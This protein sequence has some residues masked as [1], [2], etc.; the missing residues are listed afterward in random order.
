VY[1]HELHWFN[2]IWNWLGG[3]A[4]ISALFYA[5]VHYKRNRLSGMRT[6]N[7]GM[8]EL[9]DGAMDHYRRIKKMLDDANVL[10]EEYKAKNDKLTRKCYNDGWRNA[11]NYL[12]SFQHAFCVIFTK[13]S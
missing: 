7:K 1:E 3:L 5:I 10:L 4:G 13:N 2:Q 9:A 11:N 6:T 12:A 8:Q